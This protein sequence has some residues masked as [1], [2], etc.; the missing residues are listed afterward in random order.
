MRWA[1][2]C[3]LLLAVLVAPRSAAATPTLTILAP[4]TLP[5]H[6]STT[7]GSGAAT[8]TV[9][10]RND[11]AAPA[12]NLVF[13]PEGK[14]SAH[15]GVTSS[16][17]RV[18]PHSSAT[19]PLTF[20]S[21][22]EEVSFSG[23]LVATVNGQA[24][25]AVALTVDRAKEAA[26]WLWLVILVPLGVAVAVVGFAWRRHKKRHSD[27]RLDH[28]F[29]SA[30]WDFQKSW[31]S[32]LT[33]VGALLSTV[34]ASGALPD[35]VAKSKTFA[36][37]SLLFG[38]LALLAPFV[39]I[40]TAGATGQ[41]FVWSF[42]L[43]TWLTVWATL[44]QLTTSF[45]LFQQLQTTTTLPWV[46]T[47]AMGAVLAAAAVLLVRYATNGTRW[48]LD[49]QESTTLADGSGPEWSLL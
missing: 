29:G 45:L 8:A 25:D 5:V 32:N 30:K 18:D 44:G 15:V 17:R 14:D 7:S 13:K 3:T 6:L 22:Q 12:I 46:A 9:V 21:D 31:S 11:A 28:R 37:L 19:V 20:T 42:L 48:K 2:V 34:L 16:V 41:G 23:V 4:D 39:Y 38:M 33:V 27:S 40:A 1:A 43:A 26:W 47:L 35:D 36:G 49:E 24:E 10:V